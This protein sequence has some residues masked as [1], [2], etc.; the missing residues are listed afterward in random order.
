MGS[1]SKINV[2]SQKL[3]T[4]TTGKNRDLKHRMQQHC[5]TL[6]SMKRT[7]VTRINHVIEHKWYSDYEKKM[8]IITPT[9]ARYDDY[10]MSF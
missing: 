8:V 10:K 1:E 3:F 5:S 9:M 7:F 6:N 2:L 4:W